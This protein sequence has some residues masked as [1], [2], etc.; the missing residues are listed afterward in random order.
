MTDGTFRFEAGADSLVNPPDDASA[1]R[2]RMTW[3]ARQLSYNQMCGTGYE[4][5]ER[6]VVKT[7]EAA[8]GTGYKIYYRGRCL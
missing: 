4:I 7:Q 5:T 3:L 2:T 1:E 8:I 6:K